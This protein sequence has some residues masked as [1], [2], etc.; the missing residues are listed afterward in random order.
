M[1]I[2]IILCSIQAITAL[3]DN[4]VTQTDV[5]AIENI[6]VTD[7]VVSPDSNEDIA[8][9]QD[10]NESSNHS[11]EIRDVENPKIEK[12]SSMDSNDLLQISQDGE[13]IL[14][15]TS[16][17]VSHFSHYYPTYGDNVPISV[18][19]KAIFWDIRNYVSM[20]INDAPREW[21]VF[22]DNKTFYDDGSDFEKSGHNS[23][24]ERVKYLAMT[25][26]ARNPSGGSNTDKIAVTIHLYGGKAKDDGLSSTFDLTNYDE[27]YSLIDLCTGNSSIHDINFKNFNVNDH[28]SIVDPSTTRPFIKLGSNPR[29]NPEELITNCNFTNI[30]LNPKQPIYEIGNVKDLSFDYTYPT[31]DNLI[32]FVFYSV[33]NKIK[34]DMDLGNEPILDYNLFLKN[35]TYAGAYGYDTGV[36]AVSKIVMMSL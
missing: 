29:L 24:D 13:N 9:S 5:L 26:L 3:E 16:P 33:K 4:N 6:Q 1:A 17:G 10:S 34:E 27:S 15:I 35:Q 25:K 30:I 19:F 8:V 20:H 28:P 36:S 31:L 14:G 32:K 12:S 22:L 11:D 2:F 21:D 23:Y 7:T 18:L